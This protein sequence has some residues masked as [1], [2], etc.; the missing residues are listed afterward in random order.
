MSYNSKI[1]YKNQKLE[2]FSATLQGKRMRDYPDVVTPVVARIDE[3][4]AGGAIEQSRFDQ[5]T[6]R[7]RGWYVLPKKHSQFV[8]FVIIWYEKTC[9]AGYV[10]SCSSNVELLWRTYLFSHGNSFGFTI[11]AF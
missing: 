9:L 10:L 5:D 7:R 6:A 11:S 8:Y 2:K 3:H 1:W 4:A